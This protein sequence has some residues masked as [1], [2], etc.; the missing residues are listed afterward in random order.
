MNK[1][2]PLIGMG[3]LLASCG[4]SGDLRTSVSTPTVATE[5]RLGTLNG[6]SVACDTLFDADPNVESRQL[7]KTDTV[8][9]VVF[10][11]TGTLGSAQVRLVGQESGKDNGFKTNFEGNNLDS[12]G[13][14]YTVRFN[15]DTGNGQFLP[16]SVRPLGITVNP[17]GTVIR[18][19][20]GNIRS[21]STNAAG[22]RAAVTGFSDQGSATP[23]VQSNDL[24]PVYSDCTEV[25]KS[26]QQF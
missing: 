8:V 10:S 22:F 16:T 26:S 15:A 20:R 7:I 5:Y 24:I 12:N 21:G 9:K 3:A 17:A 23:E 1:I 19:V 4:V 14:Q 18:A 6:P 25:N 13:T 11:S 2:L